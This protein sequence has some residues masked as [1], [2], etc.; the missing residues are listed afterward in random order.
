MEIDLTKPSEFV[1]GCNYWASHAGTRMWAE[2]DPEVVERDFRLLSDAGL[3]L[4]RVF[5]LW[6]DF[7]PIHLLRGGGG[8]PVEFR[9]GEDPLPDDPLG[10]AG[11]SHQAM[12]QFATFLDLAE[13]YRL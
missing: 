13:K 3:Q 7:Q 12:E 1:V 11:L 10:Q 9:H 5:P 4:L 2:W 6:P 8:R